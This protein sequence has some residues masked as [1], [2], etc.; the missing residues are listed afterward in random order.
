MRGEEALLKLIVCAD[1][2]PRRAIWEWGSEFVEAGKP[3]GRYQAE[4]IDDEREDCYEA[5]LRVQDVEPSDSRSYYLAVE[6][7]KG[8][9]RHSVHLIVRGEFY[10]YYYYQKAMFFFCMQ[11][12]NAANTTTTA[13]PFPFSPLP[14]PFFRT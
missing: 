14:K 1:P 10:Y 6:N 9:D 13:A 8:T 2:R 12:Q 4:L 7:D 11:F 3:N 5:R